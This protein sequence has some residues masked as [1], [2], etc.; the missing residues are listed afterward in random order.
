MSK[1]RIWKGSETFYETTKTKKK[2]FSSF[3]VQ[4]TKEVI[5]IIVTLLDDA[6]F[7]MHGDMKNQ[8]MLVCDSFV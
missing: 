5:I 2:Q 6:L 1:N 3:L 4:K 8:G 7:E